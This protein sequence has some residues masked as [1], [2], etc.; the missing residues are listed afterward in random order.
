MSEPTIGAMLRACLAAREWR[1]ADLIAALGQRAAETGQQPPSQP[2]VSAWLGD[3]RTI[4]TDHLCLVGDVLG[5]T[6]AERGRALQLAA[7]PRAA[8]RLAR[9][10]ARRA[11]TR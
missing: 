5:W 1:Q 9:R 2:L 3:R 4:A 10:M 7:Q 8:R 6:A 11:S